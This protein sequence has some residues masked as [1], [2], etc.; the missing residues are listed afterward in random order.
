M[1]ILGVALGALILAAGVGLYFHASGSTPTAPTIMH[2][3]SP[4]GDA[5]VAQLAT[6]VEALQRSLSAVQSQ[7]A[8][9]KQASAPDHAVAAKDSQPPELDVAAQRDQELERRRVYM[10]GVAAGF[11]NEKIDPAW[12][13]R[14]ASRVSATFEANEELRKR[15]RGVEC[16]T[17]TCRVQMDEDGSV[18]LSRQMPFL[19]L[20]LV[21]VLPSMSVDHIDQGNGHSTMILYMSSEGGAASGVGK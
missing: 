13:A 17:Q 3:A 19:S 4:A 16:R 20:S 14:V 21:D 7:L 5:P 10:A 1:K 9:Q 8:S 18:A 2:S 12:A 6:Q 15:L 11:N